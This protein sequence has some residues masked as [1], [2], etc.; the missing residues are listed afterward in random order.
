MQSDEVYTPCLIYT[1]H[2]PTLHVFHIFGHF[3]IVI[4]KKLASEP[5]RLGYF[6]YQLRKKGLIENVI[7]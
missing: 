6:H 4:W 5:S 1:V 2:G 3:V 7:E